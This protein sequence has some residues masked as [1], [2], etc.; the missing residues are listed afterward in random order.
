MWNGCIR[1]IRMMF[2]FS[3]WHGIPDL[4]G[5]SLGPRWSKWE[6]MKPLEFARLSRGS[7][8]AGGTLLG[9]MPFEEDEGYSVVVFFDALNA[10]ILSLGVLSSSTLSP[11]MMEVRV[12]WK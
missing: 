1:W 9:R 4:L 10:S 3:T 12:Y 5:Q 6:G 2:V 8:E 7:K 11:D